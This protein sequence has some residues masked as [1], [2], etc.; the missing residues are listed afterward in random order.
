MQRQLS[1]TIDARTPVA[2]PIEHKPDRIGT[3]QGTYIQ[4]LIWSNASK[5]TAAAVLEWAWSRKSILD[6]RLE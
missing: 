4:I 5:E 6:I 3:H 2:V 1:V